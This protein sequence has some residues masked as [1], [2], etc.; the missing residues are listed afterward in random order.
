M[1]EAG[2]AVHHMRFPNRSS[3]T[4]QMINS[5]LTGQTQQDDHAIHLLFSANR[6]EAVRE[7][8]DHINAG[9][10]VFID[11][12]YYSGCVY[13]AAKGNPSMD[14][15]WC[16]N[17]EVGL[18]RPDICLFLDIAAE[19]QARR[20]GFGDERYEKR[21]LQDRVR[22]LYQEMMQHEDEKEDIMVINAGGSV[23]KV[24][25]A[26]TRVLNDKI[27]EVETSQL[28]LRYVQPW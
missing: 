28:K 19:E 4:G 8:E 5:Y 10:T 27:G 14:L 9:T 15:A 3:P 12:Y 16:R 21:E 2:K 11:R 24:E 25:K 20:G 13:S 18:P 7:I 6:W 26:I 23:E 17:P 1:R 22:E